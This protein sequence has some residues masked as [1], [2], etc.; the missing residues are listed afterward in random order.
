MA[1]HSLM[2][3]DAEVLTSEG[4]FIVYYLLAQA[5]GVPIVTAPMREYGFNLAAMAELLTPR[6]RLILIANP[7]NPTGTIVR[8]N[9]LDAFLGKVPEHA[10]VVMDEAYFE[11]VD[12]REYPDSF[13][14]LRSGRQV[15]IVR[16]FSK[17]YGLAGLRI[18]Y[19]IGRAEVIDMLNKVRMAFNAGSLAQVAALAAL[20]DREH[21]EKTVRTNRAELEFLYRELSTRGI[22]YVPSFANFLFLDVGKPANDIHAGLLQRGIIIRPMAGWGFPAM[23]RVS[24]GTHDQNVRFL[25]ALDSVLGI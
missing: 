12:D 25:Q 17:A 10:L 19:G 14:Y 21:V 7:N 11:Y 23:I 15:L 16:T 13:N 9:D 8:R 1:Y 18:G 20:D 24:V 22:R 4:S 3:P 2:T 5:M 6:T